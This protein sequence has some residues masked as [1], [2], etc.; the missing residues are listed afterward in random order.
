MVEFDDDL[1]YNCTLYSLPRGAQLK[2]F[3]RHT[4]GRLRIRVRS[5]LEIVLQKCAEQEQEEQMMFGF[6]FGSEHVTAMP[7]ATEVKF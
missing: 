1:Q 7:Q 2:M 3:S 5:L 4:G 6:A